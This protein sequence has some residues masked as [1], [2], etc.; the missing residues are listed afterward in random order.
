MRKV[1]QSLRV[2]HDVSE[3]SVALMTKINNSYNTKDE[4]EKQ[5]IIEVVDDSRKRLRNY[6]KSTLKTYKII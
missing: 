2:V 5:K 4:S 6:H 1:V 3:Q